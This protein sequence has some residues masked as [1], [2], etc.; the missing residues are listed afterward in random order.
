MRQTVV[1]KYTSAHPQVAAIPR[2][3]QYFPVVSGTAPARGLF[4]DNSGLNRA[5]SAGVKRRCAPC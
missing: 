2:S 4:A 1:V 5:R 3:S